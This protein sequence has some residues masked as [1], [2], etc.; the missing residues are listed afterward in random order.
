MSR[1]EDG[2]EE[3]P[4]KLYDDTNKVTYKR[5]RF[6]GKVSSTKN[7]HFPK[8]GIFLNLACLDL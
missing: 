3:I 2:V 7:L 4:E 5:L 8:F 6:F 1:K